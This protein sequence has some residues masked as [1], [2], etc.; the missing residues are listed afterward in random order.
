MNVFYLSGVIN[1]LNIWDAV[2]KKITLGVALSLGI[3]SSFA[4]SNNIGAAAVESDNLASLA[5][6][7]ET[8]RGGLPAGKVVDM[9]AMFATENGMVEGVTK[10][11][12]QYIF[13][14]NL[15]LV[16]LETLSTKPTLAAT[17]A[18]LEKAEPDTSF[19]EDPYGNA[20]V[21][22]CETLHGSEIAFAVGGG[23]S[24]FNDDIGASDVCVFGDG[25]SISGWTIIS[26]STGARKDMRKHIRSKPMNIDIPELN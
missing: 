17:Y 5:K 1:F 3:A 11:F 7:C 4:V 18:L 24:G 13:E 2:M 21:K 25:S 9:V 12:C 16:G 20:A 15:A 26:M 10:K 23:S 8:P 22:A 14:G 19:P 6:Y